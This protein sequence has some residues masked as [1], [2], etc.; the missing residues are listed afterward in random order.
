MGIVEALCHLEI[1]L[2]TGGELK[3]KHK[4]VGRT[5]QTRRFHLVLELQ[6]Q[7]A[8]VAQ[9]GSTCA[10]LVKLLSGILI[11]LVCTHILID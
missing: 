7:L 3:G 9:L 6:M 11:M 8:F 1:R 10:F 4:Q 2:I 5:I